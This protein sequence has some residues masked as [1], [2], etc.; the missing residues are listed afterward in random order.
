MT[1]LERRMVDL[2]HDAC[3]KRCGLDIRYDGAT[4]VRE[5]NGIP[6]RWSAAIGHTMKDAITGYGSTQSEA[7][8]DLYEKWMA[9][10]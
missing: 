8:D 3:V 1:A 6:I 10:V 9:A 7:I 5:V 4:Y 2:M